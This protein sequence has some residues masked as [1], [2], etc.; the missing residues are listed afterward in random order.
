M[1]PVSMFASAP[2]SP[3]N[4]HPMMPRR[5]M[6]ER[7]EAFVRAHIGE[8]ISVAQLCQVTGVSDRSLR[9]AFSQM[10]G[11]SPKRFAVLARLEC[12]RRALTDAQGGRGAVTSIA[13]SHGFFELGR[14]AGTYKAAFG[15]SPSETLR[16][17]KDPPPPAAFKPDARASNCR[18]TSSWCSS[19]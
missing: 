11:M 3:Y 4:S 5:Q 2:F 7:A 13:M 8:P 18:R 9:H 6:V 14:F 10:R 19:R 1:K 16:G 15:E 17:R 12:A